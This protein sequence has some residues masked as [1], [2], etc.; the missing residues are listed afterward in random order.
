MA[1]TFRHHGGNIMGADLSPAPADGR[2]A[3]KRLDALAEANGL[4]KTYGG[5]GKPFRIRTDTDTHS[6]RV[7]ADRKPSQ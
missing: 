6:Y 5:I 1:D 2:E 4:S 7:A 3:R